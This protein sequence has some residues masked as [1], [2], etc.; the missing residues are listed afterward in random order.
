[1]AQTHRFRQPPRS[2]FFAGFPDL[3]LCDDVLSLL[4]AAI[5]DEPPATLATPGVIRDGFDD[6][7]D[8]LAVQ[9][10][11]AKDWIANLQQ[12]ERAR[13]DIKSLKVGYNKVFGYYIEVTHAHSAK[14][15]EGYIRKQTLTNAER[16]ITP[17]LKEYESLVLNADERRLDIEKRLFGEVCAQVTARRNELLA[18]AA[19][20][21]ELDVYAALAEVALMRSLHSTAG[22]RRASHRD[23]RRPPSSG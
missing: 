18:L 10:R 9:S 11:G 19:G 15:P 8:G 14:V 21:A 4:S 7:L 6:E 20:L 5:A 23:H 22:R 2:S 16:Y 1:M 13:L 3:P 12:T 17:E